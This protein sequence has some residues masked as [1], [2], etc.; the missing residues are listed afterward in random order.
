MTALCDI[1]KA[2]ISRIDHI[3]VEKSRRGGGTFPFIS[4]HQQAEDLQH[5]S[6]NSFTR[7]PV[8]SLSVH[9]WRQNGKRCL[10]SIFWSLWKLAGARETSAGWSVSLEGQSFNCT[11]S[12]SEALWNC[13]E[14]SGVGWW[15]GGG[16]NKPRKDADGVDESRCISKT[17]EESQ[18]A[19]EKNMLKFEDPPPPPLTS[20]PSTVSPL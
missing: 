15:K 11:G 17:N 5:C 16:L 7:K 10:Q 20:C 6:K 18:S 9:Y 12:W 8:D 1:T 19:T 4:V 2:Q 14:S 13:E 3:F